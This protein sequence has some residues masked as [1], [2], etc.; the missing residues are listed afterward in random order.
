MTKDDIE[1]DMDARYGTG[2][3]YP[4]NRRWVQ[5][6]HIE[7]ERIMKEL[8]NNRTKDKDILELGCGGAGVAA[9]HILNAK[10]I[11]ATDEVSLQKGREF[12]QGRSE[13]SFRKTDLRP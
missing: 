12:F 4:D 6:H 13:L 8:L 11:T 2:R 10:S 5:I 3:A 9:L 1:K 7:L